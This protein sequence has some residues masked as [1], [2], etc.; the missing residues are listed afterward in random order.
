LALSVPEH[1]RPFSI[2]ASISEDLLVIDCDVC[3]RREAGRSDAVGCFELPWSTGASEE[4]LFIY[5]S[6]PRF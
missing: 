6:M 4:R 1:E 5:I 3:G 2:P